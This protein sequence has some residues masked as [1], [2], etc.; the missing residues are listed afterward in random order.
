MYFVLTRGCHPFDP[1]KCELE[2]L[3]DPDEPLEEDELEQCKGCGVLYYVLALAAIFVAVI[4]HEREGNILKKSYK[5]KFRDLQ[6][7]GTYC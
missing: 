4:F 2:E 6:G 7:T 5:C 1:L 3:M